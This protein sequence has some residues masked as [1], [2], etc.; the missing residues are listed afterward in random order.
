MKE[1]T[2]ST[3][4]KIYIFD[5]VY[6]QIEKKQFYYFAKD[7]LYKTDG[8]SNYEMTNETGSF[9]VSKFSSQDVNDF[10]IFD[11]NS[12]AK[13]NIFNLVKE[14]IPM[15]YWILLNNLS[16]KV[17]YHID[18]NSSNI[19]SMSFLYYLNL[20][21]KKEWGGETIFADDNE[22]S[23]IAIDFVPGRI[24]LFDSSI[25]HKS[26]YV[27][28]DAPWRYTFNCVFQEEKNDCQSI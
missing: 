27:S 20:E 14:K 18:L 16:T 3:N 1:I 8:K 23:E 21:W 22:N 11:N 26:S 17:Y 7:S 9:L 13:S 25:P 6:T 19:P 15:R 28:H 10:K 5:D 2:T 24:V 4:K 12:I